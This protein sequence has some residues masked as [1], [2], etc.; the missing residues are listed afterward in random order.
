MEIRET[1]ACGIPEREFAINLEDG[2]IS[3]MREFVQNALEAECLNT[4]TG[5][6]ILDTMAENEWVSSISLELLETEIVFLFKG[7]RET[8]K[9]DA[10]HNEEFAEDLF[11]AMEQIVGSALYDEE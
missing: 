7:L 8:Q 4:D 5:Q 11:A 10:E 1:A 6:E 3:K 9:T 2:E